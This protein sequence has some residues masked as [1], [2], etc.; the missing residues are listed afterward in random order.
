MSLGLIIH[1]QTAQITTMAPT[2]MAANFTFFQISGHKST[3]YP[4]EKMTMFI[5]VKTLRRNVLF[6]TSDALRTYSVS[7]H[8]N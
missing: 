4:T 2:V 3:T 7:N 8:L 6:T 1:Q 5:C